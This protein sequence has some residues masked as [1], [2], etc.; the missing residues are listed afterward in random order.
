MSDDSLLLF[1]LDTVIACAADPL[2]CECERC[3]GEFSRAMNAQQRLDESEKMAAEAAERDATE[4]VRLS[5]ERW[6]R[7]AARLYGP[8]DPRGK[9]PRLR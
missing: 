1:P 2:S 8:K 4:R 6:Y 7:T 3:I 9:P 5:T